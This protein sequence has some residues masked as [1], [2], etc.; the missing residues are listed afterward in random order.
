[1][2]RGR[3]L[4]IV[5]GIAVLAIGWFAIG[6]SGKDSATTHAAAA[7]KADALPPLPTMRPKVVEPVAGAS[8]AAADDTTSVDPGLDDAGPA[9]TTAAS[10]GGR[11]S[12]GLA[13]DRA[14]VT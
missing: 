13:G 10:Q 9:P 11:P 3:L 5:A 12:G 4:S 14:S 2:R 6:A 8:A 1:M 7:A